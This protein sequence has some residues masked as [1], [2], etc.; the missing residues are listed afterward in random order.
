MVHQLCVR[1]LSQGVQS[2]EYIDRLV[3]MED[4]D[5]DD[6]GVNNFEESEETTYGQWMFKASTLGTS[7]RLVQL[8]TLLTY[9]SRD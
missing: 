5:D 8:Q 1:V 6:N 4:G 9:G 2:M 3:I 7:T